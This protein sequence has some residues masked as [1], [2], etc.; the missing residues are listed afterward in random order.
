[1]GQKALAVD[2]QVAGQPDDEAGRC[3]YAD[4]AGQD[5]QSSVENRAYDD[6]TELR[7]PVRRQLQR[8]GGRHAFQDCFGQKQGRQQ[9]G[10]NAEENKTGK[11][12]PIPIKNRVIS[13][14]RVG[15]RPLHGTMELVRMAISLSRG[16]SIIRQPT[17]PAAL[18]PKPIAMSGH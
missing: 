12:S 13:M 14:M 1:M 16:E 18:Q 8:E 4:S 11:D 7:T 9:R 15:K 5:E 10:E 2:K 6:F 3:S 17:T